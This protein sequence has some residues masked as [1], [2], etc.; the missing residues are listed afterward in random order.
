MQDI[1]AQIKEKERE[2]WHLYLA[3]QE[4]KVKYPERFRKQDFSNLRRSCEHLLNLIKEAEPDTDDYA[5]NERQGNPPSGEK[6]FS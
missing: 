3:V 6:W 1:M 5:L 2:L 4:L